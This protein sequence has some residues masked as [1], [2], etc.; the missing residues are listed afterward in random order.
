MQMEYVLKNTHTKGS[1]IKDFLEDKTSKLERYVHGHFHAR[2]N[3]AYEQDEHEAHLH[4][5]ANNVDMIGKARH[6]ILLTAIEEAVEKVERQ[7]NKHREQVQD[8]HKQPS[9]VAMAAGAES[10]ADDSEE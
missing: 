1:E 6:H 5:T 10:M 4:I 8:H 9:R 3:I 2:W 7:L